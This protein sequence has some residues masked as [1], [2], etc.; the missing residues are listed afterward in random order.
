MTVEPVDVPQS[1]VKGPIFDAHDTIGAG[2][3]DEHGSAVPVSL[4]AARYDHELD[5]REAQVSATRDA[6]G[7]RL[8]FEECAVVD[9]AASRDGS[10]D[11]VDPG[12][13]HRED[14]VPV[15]VVE[16]RTDRAYQP[17]S[18]DTWWPSPA[19]STAGT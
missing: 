5:V 4:E 7:H 18:T 9:L 12:V 3:G 19:A 14:E 16:V 17:R 6:I 13:D 10:R 1:A 11:A 2:P 15:R 8:P